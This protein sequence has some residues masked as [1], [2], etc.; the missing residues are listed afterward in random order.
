VPEPPA[1]FAG[2]SLYFPHDDWGDQAGRYAQDLRRPG[3]SQ[4]FPF[5]VSC[6][7]ADAQVLVTWPEANTVVPRAWD[8]VLEDVDS[9]KT[10]GMRTQS[11]YRY[12]NGPAGA[13]RHF[14][15]V[16][17][18]ATPERE[19]HLTGV[20]ARQAPNAGV[21]VVFGLNRAADVSVEI[22]NIAGRLV[23]RQEIGRVGAGSVTSAVWNGLSDQG[24]RVPQGRYLIQLTARTED[25]RRTSA[26]TSVY[27]AR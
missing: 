22:R 6:Q 25:F 18:P 10:V 5:T 26:V 20:S 14:V 9:S 13:L 4:R 7:A 2:V 12:T 1:P 17:S 3:E 8:L 11:G 16:A 15:V 27:L 23:R 24:N 19:V 21:Q